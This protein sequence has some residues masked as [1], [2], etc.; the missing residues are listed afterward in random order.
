MVIHVYHNIKLQRIIRDYRKIIT[1][2]DKRMETMEPKRIGSRPLWVALVGVVLLSQLLC[3]CNAMKKFMSSDLASDEDFIIGQLYEDEYVKESPYVPAKT[4][5]QKQRTKDDKKAKRN[6]VASASLEALRTSGDDKALYDVLMTWMGTPYKY[7][8]TTH[9]GV[10]CSG[11]VGN[12]YQ[13]RYGIKLHR[14]AN[15]IQ[16]DVTIIDR[17]DLQEGD[18][19]FFVNSHGKVSHVGIFL[20]D[21]VFVHSSTSNGVS[22]SRFESGY[23]SQHFYRCG[24]VKGKK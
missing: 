7:G 6:S 21:D 2:P 3:S 5:E 11:F 12:V 22:L 23:W 4:T 13:S 15:D 10:D 24:R 9:D 18:I 17:D 14:T 20:K 16:Q 8:G 19:L 1:G